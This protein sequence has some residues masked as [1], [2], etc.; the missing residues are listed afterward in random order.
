MLILL[1]FQA[2]FTN[3]ITVKS[4]MPEKITQ[5]EEFIVELTVNKKELKGFALLSQVLPEGFTA[6]AIENK[7]ASFTFSDQRV[8]F[9][10][11]EL[12]EEEE[13]TITYKVTTKASVSGEKQITGSFSYLINSDK[14]V[15]NIPSSTISIK[16]KEIAQSPPEEPEEEIEQEPVVAIVTCDRNIDYNTDSNSEFI[17]EISINK[18]D[19]GEF[20]KLQEIIPVGF[21]ATAIES[22]KAQFSFTN[23]M[24]KFVWMNLPEQEE[25]KVSYRVKKAAVISGD[26]FV[27]GEFSYVEIDGETKKCIISKELLDIKPEEEIIAVKPV[28]PE[29]VKPDPVKP[30]V[31][32][33]QKVPAPKQNGIRYKV[34]IAAGHTLVYPA[35]FTQKYNINE[36]IYT[37]MHEGW[38]KYTIGGYT[39]YSA[40]KAN[41]ET[42]TSDYKLDTGPFVT[43]YNNGQRIT[44]QEALMISNQK[45]VK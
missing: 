14:K 7:D 21:S 34:Q 15:Y 6:T 26:Y 11:I 20:A 43:A 24:V 33:T 18:T 44:V 10:W 42:T 30:L 5:G 17:V 8:K 13:F 4:K 31:E 3:E 22:N 32:I 40:A 29:Q 1:I 27:N 38:N 9:I 16:E 35:Y 25:F 37:E 23:Q 12:P 45:W 41:R 19:I 39:E 28:E 2:I 36:E